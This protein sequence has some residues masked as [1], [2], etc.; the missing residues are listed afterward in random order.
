MKQTYFARLVLVTL[1]YQLSWAQNLELDTTAVRIILDQNG[2]ETTSVASVAAYKENRVD[3]LDLSGLGIVTLSDY[4]GS[5][6]ALTS[7]TLS[8][9]LL[10]SLPAA[11]WGLTELSLLDLSENLI[12]ELSDSCGNLT[13]L[14]FLNVSGNQ[15]TDLPGTLK[16]LSDLEYF[17]AGGNQ[18][19]QVS[20]DYVYMFFLKFMDL[21]DN[22]INTIPAEFSLLEE[23]DSLDLRINELTTLYEGMTDLTGVQKAY[24]AANYIC[25]FSSALW[26]W[27]QARDPE[28]GATNY[29]QCIDGKP[30]YASI[31]AQ[32]SVGQQ[33]ALEFQRNGMQV[34]LSMSNLTDLPVTLF[35]LDGK[36]VPFHT[37]HRTQ[38]RLVISYVRRSEPT[39]L[40]IGS[41]ENSQKY[42][43][44]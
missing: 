2:L 22:Q 20:P 31:I 36:K 34:Q 30:A 15:I 6:D 40:V 11:L 21:S 33:Y 28:F 37:V 35:S 44:P 41:H 17:G 27:A 13:N 43:I 5:L 24:L 42:R 14:L 38:E 23:L 12:S 19:T 7:L 4:I 10:D 3:K 26:V 25:N 8:N 16:N 18:L 1:A 29:Q 39:F 32:G 9:N